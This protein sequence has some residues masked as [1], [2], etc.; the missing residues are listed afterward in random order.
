MCDDYVL[1]KTLAAVLD[2]ANVA[3]ALFNEK[4]RAQITLN[5][6]GD[7]VVC[8]DVAG[9]VSYLNIVAERLTGW[10]RAEA[11]GQPFEMVLR[12]I[13]SATGARILNPMK[14]AALHDTTI[15]L[16]SSCI[17]VRRDGEELPIEDSSAPI[18]DRGGAIVGAVMVFH[19]VS[20][21]RALT[22]QLAHFAQHDSLTD[23][24][25]RLLLND[26]FKKALLSAKRHDTELSVLYQDL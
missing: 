17:L 9:N 14:A 5:S 7:A 19:D 22:N 4:E 15:A 2:R 26:L 13:D 11:I 21:T 6:I 1:P 25:N 20:T 3:D 8:T 10:P 23:L 16:P 24:P 12:I 18:H